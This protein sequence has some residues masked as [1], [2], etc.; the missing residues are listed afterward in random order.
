[1]LL[2]F[3]Q[4]VLEAFHRASLLHGP[5]VCVLIPLYIDLDIHECYRRVSVTFFQLSLVKNSWEYSDFKHKVCISTCRLH[6]RTD[7]V[8]V[9]P[10]EKPLVASLM[11]TTESQS[12]PCCCKNEICPTEELVHWF[13][14][15]SIC[16]F[17]ST[18]RRV[19]GTFILVSL[20][21]NSWEYVACI[22]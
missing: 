13:V 9:S 16:I 17:T 21:K 10:P 6:F 11:D 7:I 5:L 18:F 12:C 1:M 2:H 22:L 4:C 20:V 3:N 19:S 15:W 8:C 14:S